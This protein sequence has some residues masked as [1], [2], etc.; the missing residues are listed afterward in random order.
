MG[1]GIGKVMGLI[2]GLAIIGLLGILV[3]FVLGIYKVIAFIF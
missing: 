2:N 1:E 3:L